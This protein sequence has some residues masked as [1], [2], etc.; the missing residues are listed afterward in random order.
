MRTLVRWHNRS[1]V[2]IAPKKII[3][4]ADG[5]VSL[6]SL[7][8]ISTVPAEFVPVLLKTLSLVPHGFS[9]RIRNTPAKSSVAN[10]S[11]RCAAATARA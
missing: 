10:L 4:M 3:T 5:C 8:S 7:E 6:I 11:K 1:L 9:G 2:I